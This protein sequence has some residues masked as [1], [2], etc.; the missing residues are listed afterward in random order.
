MRVL[1]TNKA[2]SASL[3]SEGGGPLSAASG[4]HRNALV[5][6]RLDS[7]WRAPVSTLT[8]KIIIDLGAS[9]QCNAAAVFDLH[10][11]SVLVQRVSLLT[12][13][14]VAGPWTKQA[15]LVHGGRKDWGAAFAGVWS[16]YWMVEVAPS[17]LF[18]TR[19]EIGEIWLGLATDLGRGEASREVTSTDQVVVNGSQATKFGE[20]IV[21]LSLRWGTMTFDD[22]AEL[23]RIKQDLGG[24][25]RPLALW[26]SVGRPGSV[27]LGRMA[28]GM[29]WSESEPLCSG[30]EWTF[31]EMERVLRG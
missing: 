31:T 11:G 5:D 8:H 26:P 18:S 14:S 22:R 23:H 13:A 25:L 1:T 4:Y 9:S 17:T 30:L 6:G 10:A 28:P 29:T 20:E 2:A 15:D 27:Y 16:R 12:A 21:S 24:S 3:L 7:V 19:P